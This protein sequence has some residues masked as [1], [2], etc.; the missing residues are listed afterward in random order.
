MRALL[1]ALLLAALCVTEAAAYSLRTGVSETCHEKITTQALLDV[2]SGLDPD[3]RVPLPTS[4]TWDRL[5]KA[6]V[7]A[8]GLAE[9]Y[10]QIAEPQP[11]LVLIS[12]LIGVR[13]PDTEG[14]SVFNLDGLRRL[15]A[16]PSPEGQYA[17]ALRG[18]DDDGPAG[19]LAAVEGTRRAITE[20]VEGIAA[21]VARPPED[22]IITAEIYLD[23]YGL[24][25]VEVW[26]P[27]YL[28]G[29]AM[30]AVQDSFA[31]AVRSDDLMRVVHVLNYVDAIAGDLHVA[32][33]GLAHSDLMDTCDEDGP[34]APMVMM[35]TQATGELARAVLRRVN[36]ADRQALPGFLDRWL[37]YEPGCDPAGTCNSAW[38][39]VAR[40]EPTGPY[41]AEILGCRASPGGGPGA[42]WLL[43][44]CLPLLRRRAIGLA[45]LLL[46]APRPALAEGFIELEGHGSLLSDL[47]ERSVLSATFG[48]GLRG[49][50]RWDGVGAFLHV[51]R[52]W[53]LSSEL[54]LRVE[55]GALNIAAGVE[56]LFF[57]GFAR[58]SFAIGPSILL[59]DTPLD[60]AGAVGIYADLRPMGLRWHLW[61]TLH[62][63]L[64][65]LALALVAPV[66]GDVP[67]ALTEYRTLLSV[68][69]TL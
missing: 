51:E 28:L 42:G 13:S 35:A 33:D 56:Y 52:N 11:R 24:V 57:D 36:E 3:D 17:H 29:R 22:Q 67:L 47:P 21:A 63:G 49:G 10:P 2:L 40:K 20:L 8:Q 4:R 27:A 58:S 45:A 50:Y 44:L 46:L 25:P 15:H 32:T 41:L 12:V 18:P 7:A 26:E 23:F 55:P 31:H 68:E 66:V 59:F 5:S 62:L 43:L 61:E 34:T 19:D 1:T 69:T 65:P 9:R 16:D 14:H 38:I 60:D 48:A 6:I 54:D 30:H 39:E 53:W 37:T 64:V